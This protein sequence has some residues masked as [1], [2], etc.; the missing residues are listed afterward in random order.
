[1][2]GDGG[3][4]GARQTSHALHLHRSQLRSTLLPHHGKQVSK[5]VSPGNS[6]SQDT[7]GSD[8]GVLG[9]ARGSAGGNEGEGAIGGSGGDGGCGGTRQMSH[10]LHLQRWQF[11]SALLPHH[12]KQVS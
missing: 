1:M 4:L 10:A 2:A 3:A 12:A 9:A 7:G 8:G 5:S 11:D 6:D